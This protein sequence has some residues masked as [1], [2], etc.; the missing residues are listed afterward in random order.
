MAKTDAKSM[1]ISVTADIEG[2]QDHIIVGA[3]HGFA[4]LDRKTAKHV[5]IKKLWNEKDG[6][7]IEE[8]CV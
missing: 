2:S 6:P 7:E 4:L 8:R 3:K 1:T 5:Y